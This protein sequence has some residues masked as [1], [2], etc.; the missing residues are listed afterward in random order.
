MGVEDERRE[1]KASWEW[2]PRAR[3]VNGELRHGVLKAVCSFLNGPGGEVW[4]GVDDQ[5]LAQGLEGELIRLGSGARDTLEGKIREAMKQNLQPQPFGLVQARWEEKEG[6]TLLC[7]VC[8]SSPQPVALLRKNPASGQ[9]ER[10]VW[11]RDGNRC[12][13]RS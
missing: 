8:S 1:F 9:Q 5:G 3:R 7:L 11:V 4:L 12:V 6:R 10:E 13:R 2:D